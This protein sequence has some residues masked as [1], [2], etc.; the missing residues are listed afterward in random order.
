MLTYWHSDGA[1]RKPPMLSSQSKPSSKRA[2]E[3]ATRYMKSTGWEH[4]QVAGWIS[5]IDPAVANAIYD[6][7]MLPSIENHGSAARPHSA[8]SIRDLIRLGSIR[9]KSV[10]G[11]HAYT[12]ELLSEDEILILN[13]NK[14]VVPTWLPKQFEWCEGSKC[15]VS[16]PPAGANLITA[17]QIPLNIFPDRRDYGQHRMSRQSAITAHYRELAL[18]RRFLL[19]LLSFPDWELAL[20]T[21]KP[22]RNEAIRGVRAL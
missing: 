19:S 15:W 7:V 17:E 12:K 21:R 6:D 10:L 11:Q 16:R 5:A 13:E 14:I 18:P 20:V 3:Q 4:I 2:K 1:T 8:P 9:S 22:S